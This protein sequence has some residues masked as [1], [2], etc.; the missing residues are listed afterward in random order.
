VDTA[1]YKLQVLIISAAF[2]SVAGSLRTH[3]NLHV[4]PASC[5]FINSV[6]LV[7]MAAVGGLASI[8][9]A[10]FGA[11]LVH[12]IRP[13]MRE[14]MPRLLNF[15]SGEHELIAYGVILVAIMI[16]MPNGLVAGISERLRRRGKPKEVEEHV[17][18]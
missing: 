4:S 15:R 3:Y 1:G 12:L 11:G 9:G 7:V 6:E 17:P 13:I 5:A 8:W 16:F 10:P 14:L 18:A 2:A